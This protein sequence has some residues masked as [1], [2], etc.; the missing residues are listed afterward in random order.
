[1]KVKVEQNDISK[2]LSAG[3]MKIFTNDVVPTWI[4]EVFSTKDSWPNIDAHLE[5]LQFYWDQ[6]LGDYYPHK[7]DKNTDTYRKV[8]QKRSSFHLLKLFQAKTRLCDLHN[9]MK[10]RSDQVVLD[11]FRRWVDDEAAMKDQD[12]QV[13]FGKEYC[14]VK[15]W[16]FL[17]KAFNKEQRS[18]SH[19]FC[20]HCI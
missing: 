9:L 5:K 7:I 18:I 14:D 20:Y 11:E 13:E 17:W 2:P 19:S 1:M 8:F 16:K 3:T 6:Y 4:A 12:K 15:E 10:N